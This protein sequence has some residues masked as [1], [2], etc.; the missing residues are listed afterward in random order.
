MGIRVRIIP[1]WQLH[2]LS[3]T[4]DVASI[5]VT[6]FS[7]VQTLTL[8]STP[9]NDGLLLIK[10]IMDYSLAKL[11][12]LNEADGPAF[13]IRNGPRPPIPR[14]VDEYEIWQHRRLSMKP[15]LTCYWQIAPRR[16]DLSFDEWMKLDLAYIDNWSLQTD[17]MLLF[18]TAVAVLTGAGR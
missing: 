6:E 13:K 10:D 15:G 4:P 17:F 16:N 5:R 12:D 1:D 11:K 7:G 14:E 18:K 2:Y 3:Y 9:R 8:Q